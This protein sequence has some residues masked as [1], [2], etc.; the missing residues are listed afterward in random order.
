MSNLPDDSAFVDPS[1]T[2]SGFKA[3]T[4]QML[5]YLR[6]LLG[7]AGDPVSARQALG[8]SG[9]PVAYN[10]RGAWAG[11]AVYALNDL[12]TNSGVVYL[13]LLAHT[14]GTF[15]TD[16]AA[17]KWM[18]WQGVTLQQ[19][20]GTGAGQGTQI[21]GFIQ[22][23][24]GSVPRS[25]QDK[26]R[27]WVSIRDKGALMDGTTL[28]STAIQAALTNHQRV[29]FPEGSALA[30]GIT[31]PAAVREIIGTTKLLANTNSSTVLQFLA[32]TSRQHGKNLNGL[33]INGNGKTGITGLLFGSLTNNPSAGAK[34][35]VLYVDTSNVT[36]RSCETGVKHDVSM[37]HTSKNLACISNT[38]GMKIYSDPINGGCNANS[39]YGLR[40]NSNQVGMVIAS[41]APYPLHNNGFYGVTV[42][43]NS[44]C[45]I[46]V[47]GLSTGTVSSITMDSVHFEANALGAVASAVIDARTILRCQM[48]IQSWASVSLSNSALSTNISPGIVLRDNAVLHAHNITG[49]GNQQ[50]I[51]YDVDATSKVYE[52]G[53]AVGAGIKYIE[54]Y[55]YFDTAAGP[56]LC[57][58]IGAPILSI[59]PY[60]NASPL[61]SNV[62]PTINN[63]I[64]ATS[65]SA[66]DATFGE[67]TTLTFAAS[68][69]STATNRNYWAGAGGSAGDY[70]IMSVLVKSSAAGSFTFRFTDGTRILP[71]TVDMLAGKW[72]R[73]LCV[74]TLATGVALQ[75]FIYPNDSVGAT[76]SFK[77]F[78]NYST[79]D[80]SE[81]NDIYSNGRV[82]DGGDGVR[83]IASSATLT[84]TP[85]GSETFLISGSTNITSMVATGFSGRTVTLVFQG[86]LTFTDGSNLKLNGNFITTA[87]DTITLT[88]DG[89]NWYEI[90][91][92]AN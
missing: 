45:G 28:D 38:V 9:V 30:D 14:A 1:V 40:L 57:A 11:G 47:R 16:L 29:V 82:G 60:K 54:S 10:N 76:L 50:G 8:L 64:T 3:A 39:F 44:L 17:G 33:E 79:P 5:S 58:A 80:I 74:T 61:A 2:E 89:L 72:R 21:L 70:T 22:A 19:L 73:V 66:T 87:D 81:I 92:S 46:H 62:V 49:Y 71:V 12:V 18:V 56:S 86:A 26:E 65:G 41:Q 32:D 84:L 37:E 4:T 78:A 20:Q 83:T 53:I 75:V 23:G 55:G 6:G 48:H 15:A 69:G 51:V 34:E 63:V 36:V 85:T 88:S 91:R 59:G 24:T 52:T 27:E 43:E 42:Q 67:V 35:A 31:V 13:G 25:A 68:P 7:S 90:A 77:G